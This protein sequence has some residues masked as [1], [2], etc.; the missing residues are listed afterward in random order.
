MLKKVKP[1]EAKK[2]TNANSIVKQSIDSLSSARHGHIW[3]ATL[4]SKRCAI[5]IADDSKDEL[6]IHFLSANTLDPEAKGSGTFLVQEMLKLAQKTH[7]TIRTTPENAEK[8]WKDKMGFH[9]DPLDPTQYIY[10][11]ERPSERTTVTTK[12]AKQKSLQKS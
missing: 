10:T 3:V 11:Q 12:K 1:N 8:Y 9:P 6:I 5:L 2:I 4:N 7:K